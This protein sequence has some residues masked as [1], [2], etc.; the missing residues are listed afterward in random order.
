MIS[1]GQRTS[2]FNPLSQ[3]NELNDKLNNAYYI[4]KREAEK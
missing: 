3:V 4:I 1:A 2:R